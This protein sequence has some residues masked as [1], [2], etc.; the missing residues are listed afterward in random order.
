MS[1][2]AF[3]ERFCTRMRL[4]WVN[5]ALLCFSYTRGLSWIACCYIPGILNAIQRFTY[6]KNSKDVFIR[7]KPAGETA[8]LYCYIIVLS[9]PD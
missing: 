6:Q 2:I 4:R 5:D 1:Y 3:W 9:V 7:I 8:G